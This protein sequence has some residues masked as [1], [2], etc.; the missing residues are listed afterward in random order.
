MRLAVENTWTEDRF[1][2][3]I[4][5]PSTDYVIECLNMRAMRGVLTYPQ[6]MHS[7]CCPPRNDDLGGE[8]NFSLSF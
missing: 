1:S 2:L 3:V 6:R 4:G 5:Q 8:V 7:A